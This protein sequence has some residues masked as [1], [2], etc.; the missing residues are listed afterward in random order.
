MLLFLWT[1][2]MRIPSV[3]ELLNGFS[4]LTRAERICALRRIK[5]LDKEALDGLE[6]EENITRE[7]ADRL[8]ENMVGLYSLPFGVGVN[9]VIDGHDYIIPMVIEE[10]SVIAAASKT[11]K[12]ICQNGS[13]TTSVNEWFGT[14][15]IQIPI[16]N[17]LSLLREYLNNRAEELLERLNQF[18]LHSMVMRGG[19]AR[20]I[21]LRTINRHD[22]RVMAVIHLHIDTQD[23]MGANTINQCCEYLANLIERDTYENANLKIITNLSK[24][25]IVK[26]RADIAMPLEQARAI[27]DASLFAQL[28][29]YRAT[30]HNKGVMNGIDAVLLATGNDWRAVEAG[31]HAYACRSGTYQPIT[32]WQVKNG[33]LTGEFEAPIDVGTVGGVTKIHPL[34]QLSLKIL[35]VNKATDLAR[36]VA[37]VGLVQNLGA[38]RALTG[39]GIT[40][41]HMKLHTSNLMMQCN[42]E[43]RYVPVIQQQLME[44]LSEKGHLNQSDVA[45]LYLELKRDDAK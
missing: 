30:T 39:E 33:R 6:Q 27:E 26:A 19:G 22:G 35:N 32:T 3:A 18:M 21:F 17:N 42:I 5:H 2:Y 11:A 45:K 9:F 8:I 1:V 40:R 24:N 37:A 14:G 36:I 28:D 34:A 25:K 29:P 12:Y 31:I 44:L 38:L 15:Q 10:T 43:E 23:A 4:R 20:E 13:L 41:G 7:A 16:V